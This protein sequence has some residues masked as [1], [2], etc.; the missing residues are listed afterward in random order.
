MEL[1][2]RIEAFFDIL[3]TRNV[4]DRDRGGQ[5]AVCGGLAGRRRLCATATTARAWRRRPRSHG[6]ISRSQG[7]VVVTPVIAGAVAGDHGREVL[8]FAAHFDVTL[9]DA[10]MRLIGAYVVVRVGVLLFAASLGNKSWMQ[11]W[12]GRATFAHLAGDRRGVSG[13]ARSHHR[14]PRQ[15]RHGGRQDA[16]SPCGRC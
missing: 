4:D 5:P 2:R 15:H 8:L 13:L 14:H 1:W 7:I 6:P 16:A 11:H 9:V 10:A 12:E 3:F